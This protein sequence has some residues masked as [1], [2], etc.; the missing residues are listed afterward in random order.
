MKERLKSIFDPDGRT[1]FGPVQVPRRNQNPGSSASG[2]KD[3]EETFVAKMR[4]DMALSQKAESVQRL[5]GHDTNRE[6]TLWQKA[7][8]RVTLANRHAIAQFNKK[9]REDAICRE[10]PPG[11]Y[12]SKVKRRHYRHPFVASI[13]AVKT[14]EEYEVTHTCLGQHSITWTEPIMDAHGTILPPGTCNPYIFPLCSFGEARTEEVVV[15]GR[16]STVSLPPEL[17]RPN[18]SQQRALVW[19]MLRLASQPSRIFHRRDSSGA[20][21]THALLIANT[22][23]ALTLC[24]E[25]YRLHPHLLMQA[26]GP[27]FFTGEHGLHV[28]AVN[29]REAELC[30]ALDLCRTYLTASMY[31]DLLSMQAVGGF[32]KG[33]LTTFYGSTLL[34]FIASFGL[35]RAFKLLAEAEGSHAPG[36][37]LLLSFH[38][39]RVPHACRSVSQ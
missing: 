7:H 33:K 19:L 18:A 24:M 16:H 35:M 29:R 13:V 30:E 4:S 37:R 20:Y 14:G 26:H 9:V 28:L 5:F 10:D 23:G 36:G 22:E 39:A 32:F 12:T 3:G 25:L 38:A 34:N 8:R 31:S 1:G 2:E 21:M 6:K 17:V 15:K 11:V 27:G